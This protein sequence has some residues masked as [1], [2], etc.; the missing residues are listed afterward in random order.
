MAALDPAELC[1]TPDHLNSEMVGGHRFK[2]L[3]VGGS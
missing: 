2:A 3:H 1:Q